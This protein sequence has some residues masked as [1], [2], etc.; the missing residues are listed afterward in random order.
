L[1][2]GAEP[3]FGFRGAE[4]GEA[5]EGEQTAFILRISNYD[6]DIMIEFTYLWAQ[7]R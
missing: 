2:T 1:G 5:Q 6:I 4:N 3:I 7:E